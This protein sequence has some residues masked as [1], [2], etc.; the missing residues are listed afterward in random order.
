M[1]VVSWRID[2]DS[3]AYFLR[4]CDLNGLTKQEGFKNMVDFFRDLQPI[5]IEEKKPQSKS[6]SCDLWY[7]GEKK[8]IVER[9]HKCF[10]KYGGELRK[11]GRCFLINENFV[12]YILYRTLSKYES[13]VVKMTGSCVKQLEAIALDTG[14]TP[15]IAMLVKSDDALPFY[16]LLPL[17]SIGTVLVE[18]GFRNAGYPFFRRK[19]GE[20]LKAKVS[21][22][23]AIFIHVRHEADKKALL[24]ACENGGERPEWARA[25]YD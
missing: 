25:F 4:Y 17:N 24:E 23:D 12:I 11:K 22:E 7:N 9:V 10:S 6:Q 1:P 13:K 15:L 19:N 20:S 8:D 18:A 16:G 21:E 3:L 5:E 14:T 2:E